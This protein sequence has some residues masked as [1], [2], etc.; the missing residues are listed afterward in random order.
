MIK[1]DEARQLSGPNFLVV[2]EFLSFIEKKI[3]LAA[4]D[5]KREVVIR[6]LPYRSWL[7]SEKDMIPEAVQALNIIRNNGFIVKHYD[8]SPLYDQW[9]LLIAWD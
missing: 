2:D 4:N 8:Q 6:E 1:A 5:K 3:R 7:Y 9:G